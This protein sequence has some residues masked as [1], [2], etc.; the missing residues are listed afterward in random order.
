MRMP[1]VLKHF[2]LLRS[3]LQPT[4]A[5]STTDYENMALTKA[6]KEVE[7]MRGLLKSDSDPTVF[8]TD[9]Q[10]ALKLSENP[11]SH[12]RTKHVAIH[13]IT[14]RRRLLIRSCESVYS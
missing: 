12:G 8:S 1:S 9:N 13:T 6:C 7:W 14:S 3:T 4:G 5:L 2:R 10:G 11:V